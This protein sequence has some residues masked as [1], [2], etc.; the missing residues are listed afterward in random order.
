MGAISDFGSDLRRYCP[1]AQTDSL[2]AR[3]G[4][5]AARGSWEPRRRR[6]RTFNEPRGRNGR[7]R[8]ALSQQPTF[9]VGRRLSRRWE[10]GQ[11]HAEAQ[12]WASC[13][14]V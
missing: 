13:G 5:G 6:G 10:P 9:G 12:G 2:A 1:L 3:G 11:D 14:A 4:G 8:R 7:R